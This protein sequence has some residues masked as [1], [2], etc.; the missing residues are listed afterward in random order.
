MCYIDL[1]SKFSTKF[2]FAYV[3]VPEYLGDAEFVKRKVHVTYGDEMAKE[4]TP[5]VIIFASVSKKDR[6]AAIEALSAMDNK[7][8]LMGHTDYPEFCKSLWEKVPVK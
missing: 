4:D 1:T 7:M 5:Y 8:L 6:T 3:D 2:S